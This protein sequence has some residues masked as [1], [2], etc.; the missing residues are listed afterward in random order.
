MMVLVELTDYDGNDCFWYLDEFD[1]YG[2]LDC[3]IMD[4]VIQKKWKGKYDINASIF[5]YSTSYVC[6]V[7]KH[8]IFA[9]DRVFSEL[10][11]EMFTLNCSD[12]T[13]YFKMNVWMN[14]MNLRFQ[15]DVSIVVLFAIGF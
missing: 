3:R 13:H 6:L 12:K 10:R 14:S 9:T 1:M 15:I 11:H 2:L 5:D 8:Q 4:R 7:D